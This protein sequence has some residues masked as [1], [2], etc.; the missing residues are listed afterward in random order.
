MNRMT[1]ARVAL[2]TLTLITII[3]A[4][5]TLAAAVRPH[6]KSAPSMTAARGRLMVFG[7]RSAAQ[8]AS[9]AGAK[10]DAALAALARNSSAALPGVALSDLRGL[11]PALRF[12]VSRSTGSGF[13]AVDAVT[14]GDPQALKAALVKLG[15]ENP[16]V[17]LNDVGGWLPL[18]AINAAA[19]LP[20]LHSIR[21]AMSRTN[22]GSVE[23]QGDFA[24][25]TSELRA[26]SGLDGTGITVGILSD[27]YNC[28]A[29]YASQ[30]VP[31]S[32]ITGYAQNGF[33][34][35]ASTDISTAD[36]PASSN[37]NILEEAGAGS[38]GNGLCS[39]DP[40]YD[41]PNG[42][43]GR[44][45]MQ[46]VHDVAPVAKLAFYTAVNSEADMANGIQA[47][48]GAGAQVIADDVTYFDEPF[49]Q[50]GLVAQAINTVNASGVAYFSAAGNNGAIG[51]DNLAPSFATAST[52]P[53][54]EMLMNFDTSGA[55]TTTLMTAAIPALPPGDFIA[56]VLEWD[57]PYVTGSPNSG[58]ATSQMDLCLNGTG[59]GLLASPDNPDP[60]SSSSTTPIT[61][62]IQVCTGA[63]SAGVDPY[64]ILVIGYPADDPANAGN[65]V[66]C[67]ADYDLPAGTTC[68]AAQNIT[69]QVG[70]AAGTTPHRIKLV[71]EDNGAGVTY[72]GPIVPTGGTLQGHP[73]AATAM[74][75]GAAYW[76][77]TPACGQ[78]PALLETF[79]AKGGD[80][81]LFDTSGARLSTPVTRQKPDIIGPDGVNNTF[82]G[83][84]LGASDGGS[85]NCADDANYPN[86]LGTSA[87]TPHVAAAAAL[88]LQKTPGL[89]PAVIYQTLQKSAV[90]MATPAP[91]YLTGYGFIQAGNAASDEPTAPDVTLNLS[92]T[93][94]DVGA[95]AT[96]SWT[97]TNA[98]S[99]TASGAWSGTQGLTGSLVVKPTSANSYSY[100][101]T[102]VN[103][104]G[105][106]V[107]TQVLTVVSSGGGGGGGAL[108]LTALLALAGLLGARRAR[109][110][111]A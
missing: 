101:L 16:A 105:K 60:N 52:S 77:N 13:V 19:A 88:L 5:A 30:G 73:G 87:A 85:G 48:A 9:A 53:K 35:T 59:K 24:Q 61:N 20:N 102:C 26:S 15:L 67:P 34:A 79:S 22:T 12:R 37:I 46:I 71:V 100:T 43:E 33:T 68:S 42:D 65:G 23:S 38:S 56:I 6:A 40:T 58:G 81:I 50:D 98:T 83:V 51:Y 62:G 104:N 36:L 74:A 95:S 63:N 3:G 44:A 94:I 109:R 108:D 39:Y 45:M 1:S 28:Y 86:F 64:Q 8:Q 75:I 47:L 80:P 99:C 25:G 31:A 21:A 57:Q 89:A 72:P 106:T 103:D 54:G 29:T 7:G 11:N 18:S 78:S 93:T 66:A 55:T 97:V 2:A 107:A 90:P 27:S 110:Q 70:L 92:P 91:D 96:L 10:F 76:Y 111:R 32:G 41:L 84:V 17:Y 14:R 4:G 69:I 49:F 82:L